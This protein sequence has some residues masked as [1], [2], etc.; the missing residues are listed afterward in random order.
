MHCMEVGPGAWHTQGRE[1]TCVFYGSEDLRTVV[2][3]VP[4]LSEP[5]PPPSANMTITLTGTTMT[6]NEAYK[7]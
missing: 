1:L 7:W 4:Q 6:A 5:A 3:L 2:Q